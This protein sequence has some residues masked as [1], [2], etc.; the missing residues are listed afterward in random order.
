VAEALHKASK[1]HGEQ[2]DTL[3]GIVQTLMR[4]SDED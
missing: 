1:L 4:S 3:D 2:A